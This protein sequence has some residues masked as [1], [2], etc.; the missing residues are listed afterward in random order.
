MLRL[1]LSKNILLFPFL[2]RVQPFYCV[3]VLAPNSHSYEA[4][5]ISNL[6]KHN[7]F[8]SCLKLSNYL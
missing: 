7:W 4:T 5:Y 3:W 2:S 1:C 8:T 6:C